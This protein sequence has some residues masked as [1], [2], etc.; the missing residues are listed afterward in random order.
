MTTSRS[1]VG[2]TKIRATIS[3]SGFSSLTIPVTLV[4]SSGD[5]QL[6]IAPSPTR[7]ASLSIPSRRAAMT[8]GTGSGSSTPS[9]KPRTEKV[10]YSSVTFSPANAALRNA[11]VS[12]TR[13]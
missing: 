1:V 5:N 13:A 8:M 4:A 9:L 6:T 12:R 3:A 11:T 10:S 7:P 2:E